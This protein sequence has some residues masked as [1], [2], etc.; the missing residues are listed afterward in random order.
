[1]TRTIFNWNEELFGLGDALAVYFKMHNAIGAQ[2]DDVDV[3]VEDKRAVDVGMNL[4]FFDDAASA[5]RR[6]LFFEDEA[7][8][9][10]FEDDERAVVVVVAVIRHE[11]EIAVEV[12]MGG[13]NSARGRRRKRL[14]EE[15]PLRDVSFR[16]NF[17]DKE[18][19]AIFVVESAE[20]E[21]GLRIV[22]V[23]TLFD[24]Q[25]VVLVDAQNGHF[26]REPGEEK[27]DLSLHVENEIYEQVALKRPL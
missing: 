26:G 27:S 22:V 13:E 12:D 6:R 20:T 1:M 10:A 3:V 25:L 18:K 9:V 5:L 7:E 2:I 23:E 8:I 24:A 19:F 14:F 16:S 15:F 11:D 17:G 4:A 21:F